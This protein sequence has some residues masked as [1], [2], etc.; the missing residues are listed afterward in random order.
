[1]TWLAISA[2]WIPLICLQ[3]FFC[4]FLN[5]EL[6]FA[7]TK[8]TNGSSDPIRPT[9]AL[10]WMENFHYL[11][12]KIPWWWAL[13]KWL[14]IICQQQQ[15]NFFSFQAFNHMRTR[16]PKY[17][18][19]LGRLLSLLYCFSHKCLRWSLLWQRRICFGDSLVPVAPMC[20]VG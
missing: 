5:K 18:L 6:V 20:K 19:Y 8:L 14:L 10:K 2:W 7:G 13:G 11:S 1:M 16:T 17:K 12:L 4:K 3:V 15:Q 9:P